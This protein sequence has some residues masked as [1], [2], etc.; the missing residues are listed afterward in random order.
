[1]SSKKQRTS[2]VLEQLLEASR[3]E[4]EYRKLLI[5][6]LE[7][8]DKRYMAVY[9]N[10][11]ESLRAK[12][13]FDLVQKVQRELKPDVDIRTKRLQTGQ[14]YDTL[15]ELRGDKRDPPI[16]IENSEGSRAWLYRARQQPLGSVAVDAPAP[17]DPVHMSENDSVD[18]DGATGLACRI[19]VLEAT[20]LA[21]F[22]LPLSET[23]QA[24]FDKWYNTLEELRRIAEAMEEGDRYDGSD[25][26]KSLDSITDTND[27]LHGN[28]VNNQSQFVKTNRVFAH[29]EL[30]DLKGRGKTHF[31]KKDLEDFEKGWLLEIKDAGEV[32][33]DP[34]FEAHCDST[35]LDLLG[36]ALTA[37][38]FQNAFPAFKDHED[39]VGAFISET[40]ISVIISWLINNMDRPT[41][42]SQ[43][44]RQNAYSRPV[45][46][47]CDNVRDLGSGKPILLA[48]LKSLR[49][50]ADQD[51]PKPTA[52]SKRVWP[53]RPGEGTT[54]EGLVIRTIIERFKPPHALQGM[55]LD[56]L[57]SK[58]NSAQE[59]IRVHMYSKL[60]QWRVEGYAKGV[61]PFLE[62]PQH[63]R[64]NSRVNFETLLT[65]LHATWVELADQANRYAVLNVAP[66]SHND[67][68]GTKR[69][70]DGGSRSFDRKG[71]KPRDEKAS[72]SRSASA[73][74][75]GEQKTL[76]KGCGKVHGSECWHTRHPGY[77]HSSMSWKDSKVGKDYASQDPPSYSLN[78]HK[79]PDGTNVDKGTYKGG[80]P[81]KSDQN[82]R[83]G[84]GGNARHGR[85]KL[86]G[87][88]CD[89]CNHEVAALTQAC[90]TND[91]FTYMPIISQN[92]STRLT[93]CLIDTGALQ[94]NYVSEG[95]AAWLAVHGN[96]QAE[97]DKITI[98]SPLS[99][100]ICVNSTRVIVCSIGVFNDH[101]MHSDS[102]AYFK[103]YVPTINLIKEL[104]PLRFRVIKLPE[105]YDLILGRPSAQQ[106][107]L[108]PRL[109]PELCA[110]SRAAGHSVLQDTDDTDRHDVAVMANMI[111]EGDEETL[112]E[113]SAPLPWDSATPDPDDAVLFSEFEKRC[114]GSPSLK[115][116]LTQ[117]CREYKDIFGLTCRTEPSVLTPFKFEVD[118]S[119]WKS[120]ITRGARPQSNSDNDEIKRQVEAMLELN[121]IRPSMSPYA[122][123]VLMVPKPNSKAK[124]FCIDL[125]RLNSCTQSMLWPIPNIHE[126]LSRIVNQSPEIFGKID[127]P[128]GYWQVAVDEV[129]RHYTAFVTFMGTYEFNRI[130]MGHK[131][132]GAYFQKEVG[133]DLL[134]GLLYVIC[135]LY[136]DDLLI[137]G[138]TEEEFLGRVRTVFDRFRQKKVIIHMEKFQLGMP[139]VEFV[140]HVIDKSGTRF[141]AEKLQGVTDFPE[142]KTHG[143]IK[144]FVGLANYFRDHVRDLTGL[145]RPL[146][147]LVKSYT[148]RKDRNRPVEWT[149]ERKEAF[150]KVKVAIQNCQKL[151]YIQ[152]GGELV[153]ETDASEYGIAA[154]LYQVFKNPDGTS[155]IHPIRFISK[156]LDRT[157]CN[158]STPEKECYAIFYTLVK[159]EHLLRD[160]HFK[161][162][163]DHKNLLR[164]YT[165]GSKKV[166]R[167]R[168]QM[169]SFDIDYEH[170]KGEDNIVA[171][172]LS[173]L[174]PSNDTSLQERA[175]EF[176][177][178]ELTS[179]AEE[180][181][182]ALEPL[183]GEIKDDF[184]REAVLHVVTDIRCEALS[185]EGYERVSPETMHH[186]VAAGTEHPSPKP[187]SNQLASANRLW[188]MVQK[189]ADE[190]RERTEL[191]AKLKAA[192][193]SE[194]G[195]QVGQ[196][197]PFYTLSKIVPR[198]DKIL[199]YVKDKVRDYPDN[200][201]KGVHADIP[202]KDTEN[203]RRNIPHEIYVCLQALHGPTVGHLGE[204][205][206]LQKALDT[207]GSWDGMR[208][209]IREFISHCPMCQK[210]RV[211]KPQVH[212]RPFTLSTRRPMDEIHI[213]TIGPLPA[214]SEGY[215][216]IMVV[217]DSCSR[218]VGLYPTK[219]VEM[220]D[221]VAVLL[222][223]IARF[224]TPSR[225]QSDKGS[226]FVN[227]MITELSAITGID[228]TYTTAYSKEENG[229]VERSNREVLRHT[230][231]LISEIKSHDK[232]GSHFT[233]LVERIMNSTI[234]SSIGVAPID[235]IYGKAI[236]LDTNMIVAQQELPKA[237]Q[238]SKWADDLIKTQV[239]LLAK[240]NALQD[241][242]EQALLQ[243]RV[244]SGVKLTSFPINSFVL[245]DYPHSG[246]G[247]TKPNKFV[248]TRQGPFMVVERITTRKGMKYKIRNLTDES[249][250]E[251][252][253]NRLS[254]F[255]FDEN[256][257][258][259]NKVAL[260]DT[261]Q[262]VVERILEHQG[263]VK[264][265][266]SLDFLVKY[267][268]LDD[269]YNNWQPYKEL[270][271]NPIL[272]KYLEDNK[273]GQLTMG[274]FKKKTNTSTST[275]TSTSTKQT[276]KRKR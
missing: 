27:K 40:K 194:I 224:G 186:I 109:H 220:K 167:W 174:C 181:L 231:N 55:T 241:E 30:K 265:K 45:D 175:Q 228:H 54:L 207:F 268:G 23:Q 223:H 201:S 153:L 8:D 158:W 29:A 111:D 205:K 103:G 171:D 219:T 78:I 58:N 141:S 135:E 206:T 262:F 11:T 263:D 179:S 165:S 198:N 77:N 36:S 239:A 247:I 119:M 57:D 67:Q 72:A 209:H 68:R 53:D 92:N 4:K 13:K 204:Q 100:G 140:G 176:T 152:A 195:D 227:Q 217:L 6:G 73:P 143:E 235:L 128:A 134:A 35:T 44:P 243:E 127:L 149:A 63:A 56:S 238:L 12:G 242:R 101:K 88:P 187:P 185:E 98:C 123:Q 62:G 252:A 157:Q 183:L 254:P 148:K 215:Q 41:E 154:F 192:R 234:H 180:T 49:E 266:E 65:T 193:S 271:T 61:P 124:R 43:A 87:T 145:M 200:I 164:A 39:P 177:E 104:I 42:D 211:I 1:M 79:K 138:K 229:M 184:L 5:D 26:D 256:E 15:V 120:Q 237:I 131:N 83:N 258:D 269:T 203:L 102:D 93:K 210:M 276:Q 190:I 151:Y 112:S 25:G 214:D 255:L 52:F 34:R 218:L 107:Q 48:M 7:K 163:T 22:G 125:R 142:P 108:L 31:V 82:Q 169:Q 226:Q 21:N 60:L 172:T 261:R 182:F 160:V 132:A 260:I 74:T 46:T 75:T 270:K 28:N 59:A 250:Q 232:W 33:L 244:K 221:A 129:C 110:T 156:S 173:R 76:C 37:A 19:S 197:R 47:F 189:Q 2:E 139:E 166:L 202:A 147:E 106:H 91:A 246:I 116:K 216:Y 10:I 137:Y 155:K 122:S 133:T 230:V 18:A 233:P 188:S 253:I 126:M 3:E 14:G 150:A 159:L 50:R 17:D 97:G 85:D 118:D 213:D 236:N 24:T 248:P 9:F 20:V 32:P 222:K 168:M 89:A 71:G 95:L 264:N 113:L 105:G 115:A 245:L 90:E 84:N 38:R 80:P 275:S 114:F 199:D 161:V 81:P 70:E 259:P 146:Q 170:V 257:I 225:I 208:S 249:T 66:R 99:G 117:L 94:G 251:V 69:S 130:P 96:Q 64:V 273:L 16:D 51:A 162:R 191:A 212:I 196:K 274:R 272:H 144:S 121:I 136:I 240:A 267:E 86:K 178:K